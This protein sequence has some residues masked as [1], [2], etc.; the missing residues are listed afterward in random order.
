MQ[1]LINIFEYLKASS[2]FLS[3]A[4]YEGLPYS[5]I[6]AMSVGLPVVASYVTG[7]CDTFEHNISGYYYSLGDIYSA[8]NYINK[9]AND[10]ELRNKM[11]EA[12][13]KRQREFFCVDRM[14]DKYEKLYFDINN[15][16]KNQ[17]YE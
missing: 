8:V 6:E 17:I 2:I 9:L 13:F 11:G 1:I 15:N 5:I 7:N 4:Y 10:L 16:F 3:T 12:S 14:K